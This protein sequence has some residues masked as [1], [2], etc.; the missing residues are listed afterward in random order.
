LYRTLLEGQIMALDGNGKGVARNA[1]AAVLLIVFLML[2]LNAARSGLA[3]L[4][5]TYAANSGQIAPANAAVGFDTSNPDAHYIRATILSSSDLPAS[6]K[7]YEQ[8]ALARPDDY[9][10]W[11]SLARARELNGDPAGAI[12][13][14]RQAVPLAPYYGEP[15]Y[16]L[17]NILLRA[18][19]REEAFKELRLAGASN[20]TL[21]PGIIDLAWRV[22]SGN[23]EFVTRA[24]AP[25]SPSTYQALGQYFRQREAVGAAI[26]MYAAAGNAADDDRNSYLRELI[27]ERRFKGAANLWLVVKGTTVAPGVMIDPGFEQESNLDGPGFGWRLGEKRQGFRLALDSNNPREGRSSL[28][29]DF[30]GDS[31]PSSPVISQLVLIEPGSHYQLRFAMRA[32][33]IVSGGLPLVMVVDA[34]AGKPLKP[35]EPFPKA[36]DGWREYT[37]DFDSGPSASAVKITLQ[38]QPCDK[39]P[40]P[41]FGRLWLDNFSLQKL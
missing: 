15:H 28:K 24:I 3:S 12:S 37:I 11:L 27:A 19:Q 29:V 41:I 21:L 20:P 13:A 17:G 22:S 14:A 7:E 31:D 4:L 23:I 30:S 33:N 1:G 2:A 9:V 36:T 34:D 10:L 18:G 35:S 38:R 26:A 32:E 5:T 16:Q 39:T 40:C 6:I 25:E 8:A